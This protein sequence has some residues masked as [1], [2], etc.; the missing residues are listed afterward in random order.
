[1]ADSLKRKL[2]TRTIREKQ[3]ILR[4][5]DRGISCDS[6][7]K[8]YNIPKQTLFHWVK[9]KQKIYSTVESNPSSKKGQQVHQ[10]P[11]KLVEKVCHT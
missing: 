1:M 3:K 11:Y 9:D 5:I 6:V 4:R 7:A 8:N 2:K 10:S